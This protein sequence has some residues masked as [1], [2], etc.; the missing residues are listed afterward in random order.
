ME[1]LGSMND[2]ANRFFEDLGR[3]ISDVSGDS[4]E[5]SFIF[6]PLVSVAKWANTLSEPQ[7]GYNGAPQIRSKSTPSRGPIP[8]PHYLPHSWTCPTYDAKRHPDPIRRFATMHWLS[9]IHI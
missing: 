9:L 3:R 5:R 4:R 8:K 7:F 2:S 6:Q 1:T